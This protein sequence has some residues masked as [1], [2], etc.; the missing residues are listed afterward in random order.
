[1]KKRIG[2]FIFIFMI[3]MLMS[4]TQPV[5]L[6]GAATSGGSP[7]DAYIDSSPSYS[8]TKLS[9]PLS[10]YYEYTGSLCGDVEP[11]SFSTAYLSFTVRLNKGGVNYIF[12]G[13]S[14]NAVC[15]QYVSESAKEVLSF[16][17]T[18]VVPGI[19]NTLKP[20]KLKSVDNARYEF[21]YE[22]GAFVADITIAVIEK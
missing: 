1:M 4:A 18:I 12:Y 11:K 14:Q 22:D 7:W 13:S 19:Y 6:F 10:I 2:L 20:W 5:L 15:T 16:F 3:A 17:N 9:G 21:G 8:G